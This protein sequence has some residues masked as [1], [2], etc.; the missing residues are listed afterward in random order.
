MPAGHVLKMVDENQIDRGATSGT[1]YGY[2]LRG[3]FLGNGYA[4]SRGDLGD[5]LNDG[6]CASSAS[7]FAAMNLAASET[8]RARAARVA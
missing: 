8:T 3:E 4:E 7:P 1:D 2:G 5:Q 6:R